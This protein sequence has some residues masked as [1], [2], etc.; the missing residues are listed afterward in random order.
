MIL[1]ENLAAWL[2]SSIRSQIAIDRKPSIRPRHEF[3]SPR[4]PILY[5]FRNEI[6]HGI[7]N[8]EMQKKD[9]VLLQDVVMAKSTKD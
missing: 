2:D 8:Y 3:A 6:V 9:V 4:G 1:F 7:R 5:L